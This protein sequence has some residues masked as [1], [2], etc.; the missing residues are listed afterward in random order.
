MPFASE[1]FE[2]ADEALTGA[3][4]HRPV[5]GQAAYHAFTVW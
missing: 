2:A 4:G 3:I 1:V 5:A